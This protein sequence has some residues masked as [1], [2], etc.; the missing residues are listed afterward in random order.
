ME[1]TKELIEKEGPDAVQLDEF[2]APIVK[3]K[4]K[5]KNN[6]LEFLDKS[7]KKVKDEDKK[8]M[9]LKKMDNMTSNAQGPTR[10]SELLLIDETQRSQ[11]K[12]HFLYDSLSESEEEEAVNKFE[13]DLKDKLMTLNNYLSAGKLSFPHTRPNNIDLIYRAEDPISGDLCSGGQ[14]KDGLRVRAK[15]NGR[16]QEMVDFKVF[17]DKKAV[18]SK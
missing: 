13:D 9:I 10:A 14:F 15:F 3:I 7:L 11:K 18:E 5:E 6:L 8:D 4:Y 1:K 12:N 17:F 2:G 16:N